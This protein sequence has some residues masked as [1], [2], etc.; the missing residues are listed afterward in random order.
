ML[1]CYG[2][3]SHHVASVLQATLYTLV[4]HTCKT[5]KKAVLPQGNHAME[6]LLLSVYSSPC[7]HYKF[8]SRQATKAQASELQTLTYRCKTEFN[9]NVD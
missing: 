7:V 4:F 9:A 6:Q 2:D 8:N 1:V 3:C 5:N